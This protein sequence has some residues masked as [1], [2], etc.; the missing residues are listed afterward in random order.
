MRVYKGSVHNKKEQ[1]PAMWLTCMCAADALCS[2]A[3][4]NFGAGVATLIHHGEPEAK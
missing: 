3:N 1:E 4:V 2:R